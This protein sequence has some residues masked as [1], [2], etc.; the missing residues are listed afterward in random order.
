MNIGSLISLASERNPDGTAF[1]WGEETFSYKE[2]AKRV[3]ALAAALRSLGL[4][5]GDRVA[6]F[7]PN[8]PQL[9]ETYFAVWQAGACVAPLNARF[10]PDE[11]IYHVEDCRARVIVFGEESREA[12]AEVRDETD[13][14][15]EYVCLKNPA[16]GQRDYEAMLREHADA[17][18]QMAEV[19]GGDPAWLFYTS[20]TTGRPK[21][22]VLTHDNLSFVAVGWCAD[23]MHLEPEDVGL[24][25]APLTH[26]AGLCALALTTKAASQVILTASGFEAEAF[27]DVV[28]RHRITNTWLVPT[29]IKRLIASP[30]LERYDLSSLQYVVYGGSPM[31]VEDIKEALRKIG[32]VFVQL[33]GQGETPMTATYLRREDHVGEG[34]EELVRR[35]ASCGYARTGMEVKV[36]DDEDREV[37]RREMGEI[38]VRG[39]SVFKEYWERPEETA[40]TLRGG[41]LHTGDLGNMDEHGYV[42]IM[43]RK[44]DMI[45][46]GGTNVYPREVEEVM[47]QHPAV[48]E[49]CVLGVPDESWGEATNAVVVLKPG[50][51]AAA[52]ELMAFCARRMAGYKKPKSIHFV[53]EL[54]KSAYGKVLKREL[55]AQYLQQT[56]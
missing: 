40:E 47:L 19:S 36:F 13:A 1:I 3:D 41:W 11:V 24:H 45:I 18:R 42:Y 43:D 35:L 4:Q 21:G 50:V 12:M 51:E 48:Q 9:L 56:S 6:V 22:A 44:K 16:E 52:E 33:Y 53:D 5:R 39:P 28:E 20:G 25:A 7:M 23:L 34:S 15:E 31:Y 49:A 30:A 17:P 38:C 2:V 26:G 55:R 14:V 27:C 10:V 32:R 8:C 37:P 29:Q 54:P 46:S